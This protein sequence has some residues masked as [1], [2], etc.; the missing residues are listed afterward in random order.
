MAYILSFVLS[1]QLSRGFSNP[2]RYPYYLNQWKWKSVEKHW[3][4]KWKSMKVEISQSSR[5]RQTHHLLHLILG[6]P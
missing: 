2:F 4:I 6:D 5:N 3:K 1:P